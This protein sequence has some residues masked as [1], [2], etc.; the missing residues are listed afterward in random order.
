MA[1]QTITELNVRKESIEKAAPSERKDE[2]KWFIHSS[3]ANDYFF[4]NAVDMWKLA[5]TNEKAAMY[6]YTA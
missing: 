5:S 1:Q 2:A 3:D 6:Q 4:D